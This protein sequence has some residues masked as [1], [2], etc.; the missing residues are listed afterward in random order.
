MPLVLLYLC[1]LLVFF[2]KNKSQKL[3]F[4]KMLVFLLPFL[5]CDGAWVLRNYLKYYRVIPGSQYLLYPRL[6]DTYYQP[7]FKLV[8]SWGGSDQ[9]WEP[10]AEIRWFGINDGLRPE[11]HNRKVSL[12]DYIYTSKFN[13]DSLLV[14]KKQLAVYISSEPDSVAANS[15]QIKLLLATIRGKCF[16]YANSIKTEKPFLYY[17]LAPIMRTKAF[18]IHSGTPN[19]FLTPTSQLNPLSY[20][21]KIFYSILYLLVI[22]LG[23]IGMLLLFRESIKFSLVA[24]ITGIVFYTI[25]IHPV[26]LGA[27]EKRYFVPTY[28]FMLICATYAINWVRVKV[29]FAVL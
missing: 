5:F 26:I 16:L 27:C 10:D 23:I 12:P 17:G 6:T 24:L 1:V 25:L 21:I 9:V 22:G 29:K 28:P 4:L 19:L 15:P 7:I 11:L 18:L 3:S 14:L 20:C 13:Y 8:R 2:M